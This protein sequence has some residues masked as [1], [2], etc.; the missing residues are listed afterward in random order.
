MLTS[1]TIDRLAPCTAIVA[2]RQIR[3]QQAGLLVHL[4]ELD[5]ALASLEREQ[6]VADFAASG[7]LDAT[8]AL[9][10]ALHTERAAQGDAFAIAALAMIA[11]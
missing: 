2:G 10:L 1:E 5:M 4:M 7:E 6:A 8:R 9:I 11:A 3:A